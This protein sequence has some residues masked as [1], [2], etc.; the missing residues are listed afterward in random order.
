MKY[1]FI[2]GTLKRSFFLRK[3]KR[4][5]LFVFNFTWLHCPW[6]VF[7]QYVMMETQ[8]KTVLLFLFVVVDIVVVLGFGVCLIVYK[9]GFS[10]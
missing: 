1:L 6:A 2:I 7:R 10:V 8:E 5:D 3:E 9:Q 4:S